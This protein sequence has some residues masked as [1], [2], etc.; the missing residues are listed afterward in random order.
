MPVDVITKGHTRHASLPD[1]AYH[2]HDRRIMQ[3]GRSSAGEM[4][5]LSRA[6]ST[7]SSTPQAEPV[8]YPHPASRQGEEKRKRSSGSTALAGQV[9]ELSVNLDQRLYIAEFTIL[10]DHS[11]EDRSFCRRRAWA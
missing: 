8:Q 1:C 9:K 10:P 5:P 6:T 11:Q 3:C 7:C 4:C 2:R